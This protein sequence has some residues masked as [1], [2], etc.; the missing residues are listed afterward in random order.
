MAEVQGES[1]TA[2]V[3]AVVA[4]LVIAVVKF[5]AGSMT[6]SS[7]MLAEGIHSLVDCG[8]GALV[9]VGMKRST[10]PPDAEHPFGHGKELYFWTFIVAI[11][12]FAIGGGMSVYEGISHLR[13]MSETTITDPTVNYIVLA[14][15]LVVEG[16]S[17]F[18][19]MKHF[20]AA[21]GETG[22]MQF[23][24]TA[25]DPS[26]F[27][28]VFEDSAAMVGLVVAFL[29]VWLGHTFENPVFDGAASII[30]GLLLMG[31]AW[32]LARETK[33]LLVGE[34]VEPELLTT[35]QAAVL[36]DEDVVQC[37]AIRS[38]YFGPTELLVNLD[39][40]FKPGMDGERIHDAITRV[41]GAIQA[42]D[43]AVTRVYI[44]V[45]SVKDLFAAGEAVTGRGE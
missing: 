5:I 31:V 40:V 29:G 33:G 32:G 4:N 19:A 45:E 20:N 23:V 43:S 7:A 39:V 41:E 37:G 1:K 9:L 15:S 10:A 35:M 11:S 42:T 14:I 16:W 8:N 44:E 6:K 2:V 36:A 25:K 24:R 13:H 38:M 12:V 17:F 21:R 26:L 27:T 28:V 18:V 22:I 34:G 30:I 3:A